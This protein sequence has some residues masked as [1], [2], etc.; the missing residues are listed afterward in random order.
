MEHNIVYAIG[1]Q[2]PSSSDSSAPIEIHRSTGQMR[3]DLSKPIEGSND[4]GDSDSG[5]DNGSSAPDDQVPSGGS[6]E[7][8]EPLRKHEKVIV[9]HAAFMFIG[10]LVLLPAGALIARYLRTFSN[11]WYK[12][13]W[14][15]QVI[16][17]ES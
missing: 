9:A 11:V 6:S 3:L 12:I 5:T 17:G 15:I 14:I 4:N 13:H 10:Y 7:E 16:A 2:R 8:E 1:P